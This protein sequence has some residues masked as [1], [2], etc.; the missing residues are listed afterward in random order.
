MRRGAA[1]EATTA[2]RTVPAPSTAAD[3]DRK[4]SPPSLAEL[5]CDSTTGALAPTKK[6]LVAQ[7]VVA[8]GGSRCLSDLALRP[9]R[10]SVPRP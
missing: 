4:L 2:P 5:Q 10:S 1:G 8:A 6:P 7:R 3:A 9:R